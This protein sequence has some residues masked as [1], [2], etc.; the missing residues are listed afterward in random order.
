METEFEERA[1]RALERAI[2]EEKSSQVEGILEEYKPNLKGILSF[3]LARENPNK[4]IVSLLLEHKADPNEVN[5][6]FGGTPLLLYCNQ[7]KL[8]LSIL[9][10]LIDHGARVAVKDAFGDTPLHRLANRR[11]G[12]EINVS[13]MKLVLSKGGDRLVHQKNFEGDNPLS[14]VCSSFEQSPKA[15]K[16][17]LSHSSET[18]VPNKILRTPLMKIC[19]HKNPNVESARILISKGANPLKKDK[20]GMNCI[21]RALE[22]EHAPLDLLKA[23]LTAK[24]VNIDESFYKGLTYLHF[25]C[26]KKLEEEKIRLLISQ[27]SN[28]QLIDRFT[29][30][31]LDYLDNEKLRKELEIFAKQVEENVKE[32]SIISNSSSKNLFFF[33]RN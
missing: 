2:N 16:L 5:Q 8:D 27:R 28:I 30:K 15:I 13:A 3:A 32:K 9:S 25:A 24:R 21:H 33:F 29:K 31:P 19:L 22:N 14:I 7:K 23:L 17:L 18:D 20:Y 4:K 12:N 1:I 10:L 26:I 6:S 11:E